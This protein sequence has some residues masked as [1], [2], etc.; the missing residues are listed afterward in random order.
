MNGY[1]RVKA[2]LAGKALD[3]RPVMLHNF[4]NCVQEGGISFDEFRGNPAQAARCFIENAEK[5]DFDGIFIDFDTA[6][7]SGACGCPVQ[8]SPDKAATTVGGV[9]ED[10]DEVSKLKPVNL[11]DS[12]YV[13]NWLETSRRIAEYFGKE[14]YVR[15]NCDQA[16]F[17]LASMLRGSQEL[18]MDLLDEDYEEELEVL[19]RYAQDV[20]SQFIRLASQTGAHGVSNGDSVAG[21]AMISPAMYEKYS[22]PYELPVID[23]AHER[24][25][26][27]TLHICGNTTPIL[28]LF[29][30][31]PVDAMEL[32]YKTDQQK[33]HDVLAD[34]IAV[35]G[36][37]DP[38]S[39]F[40]LGTEELVRQKV[41]ELL[42][43]YE[44]STR[45]IVCSGCA[46]APD[47]PE[48]NIRAFVDE[49]RKGR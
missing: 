39:V 35:S 6:T 21:P 20:T 17:S 29:T 33:M 9:L 13:M 42:E 31:L 40:L 4:Q 18:M 12:P 43:I 19:F 2:A 28:E 8:Y 45:L 47:T 41:R 23:L 24:G 32:D 37:L 1:E 7:L 48:A 49:V 30:R 25:M 10:L 15:C 11:E 34:K 16:P 22:I 26:D 44:D 5:Y 46:I 38:S 27:Y 14:K 36:T 3:L